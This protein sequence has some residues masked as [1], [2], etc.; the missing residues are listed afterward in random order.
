[1]RYLFAAFAALVYGLVS[2]QEG[3][4]PV[5]GDGRIGVAAE[6]Q[7]LVFV[8]PA[9]AER[10]SPLRSRSPI[11]PGDLV[12]T[13]GRGANAV[14]FD[15]P[16]LGSS[17]LGPGTQVE[18]TR[19]GMR[20]HAGEGECRP[21]EGKSFLLEGPGGA[22]LEV[23]EPGVYAVEGGRLVR[24]KGE[25]RWLRGFRSSTTSEWMGSLLAKV[26]GRVVPLSVGYHKVGVTIRDQI[27]ETVVEESFVNG[28]DA[29]LEGTFFF[30][31]PPDASISGFGMWIGGE[32]VEADVVERQRARR[33]FEDI[34]RRKKD[35]G[36]LEWSGGNLFKAR[37]F[38]IEPHAEKRIRIR[39]TQVLPLEGN[40]VRYRYALRSELLRAHPLRELRM[41]FKISMVRRILDLRSPTHPCRITKTEHAGS[42]EFAAS[43]FTPDRD[44]ELAI[45]VDRDEALELVAHRRGPDGYFALLLAPGD[46]GGGGRAEI[47]DGKPVEVLLVADTSASI[48]ERARREQADFIQALLGMLGPKDRFRLVCADV[49]A[50]WF[51]E[52]SR[53]PTEENLEAA[54]AFL[55]AR[56]SLGWTDFEKCFSEIFEKARPGSLVVYLGDGMPTAGEETRAGVAARLPELAKD[57]DLVCHAVSI[58]N[59]VDPLVLRSLASI[60]GGTVFDAAS[61]PAR[62]AGRLLGEALRPSLKDLEV[63]IRG[64][65]TAMLHPAS[66]PNLPLGRQQILLGRF[67]PSEKPIR[68]EV[69]VRGVL[70]GKRVTYRKAFVLDPADRG[71]SFLPRL[72]ARRHIDALLAEGLGGKIRERVLSLSR[73]YGIITPLTSFLVLESDEERAR[74]GVER[75]VR[76]RDGEEYF[77]EGR[78]H[79]DR[80][81]RR[82]LLATSKRWRVRLRARMLREIRGL[83]TDLVAEGI[84]FGVQ[85]R[86]GNLGFPGA[87]AGGYRGPGDSFAP[88][89]GG[90]RT[91]WKGASESLGIRGRAEGKAS[92][93]ARKVADAGEVEEEFEEEGLE[94]EPGE[95]PFGEEGALTL[96][97]E[98][99]FDDLDLDSEKR[100][101]AKRL[102]RA[103]AYDSGFLAGP[104]SPG[105]LREA[106]HELRMDREAG[107]S[108]RRPDPGIFRE[109]GFPELPPS[110]SPA[111]KPDTRTWTEEVRNLV[112]ILDRRGRLRE[113]PRLFAFEW[114]FERLHPLRAFLLDRDFREGAWSPKAW[115]VT[116]GGLD[117]RLR[118]DSLDGNERRARFPATG[119]A[120]RRARGP[121]DR[122]AFPIPLGD[123]SLGGI[124]RAYGR[125]SGRVLER[126]G[127]RAVIRFAAPAPSA[128]VVLLTLD[129]SRKVLLARE[130]REG[131]RLLER[132][133]W[134]EFVR[135]PGGWIAGLVVTRDGKGRLTARSRLEFRTLSPGDFEA[136]LD[137]ERALW[138]GD[139]VLPARLPS[140]REALSRIREGKAGFADRF[141]LVLDEAA[142]GR[143]GKMFEA[144]EA[145]REAA[146]GKRGLE[147]IEVECLAA[148][149]RGSALQ[150]A[151]LRLAERIA[152]EDPKFRADLADR[153]WKLAS[154]Y[155]GADE[156]GRLLEVLDPASLGLEGARI[157]ALWASRRAAWF[158]AR[159]EWEKVRDLRSEIR[160]LLPLRL[161]PILEYAN[162]LRR[163]GDLRPA[164][165]VLKETLEGA[166]PLSGAERESCHR[167]WSDL[168]WDLRDLVGLEKVLEAWIS[169]GPESPEAWIRL[170]SL[171]VLQ[172]RGEE[173]DRWV[174]ETLA[175]D[176]ASLEEPRK[177]ARVRAAIR[178]A[179]GGGWNLRLRVLDPRAVEALRKLGTA[180]ASLEDGGFGLLREIALN[181]SFRSREA[182]HRLE[183]SIVRMLVDGKVVERASI[184]KLRRL[185]AVV[186]WRSP[187]IEDDSIDRLVA[188]LRARRSTSK[189]PLE[190][191]GLGDLVLSLCDARSDLKTAVRV[192]R[193]LLEDAPAANRVQRI[194]DLMRR[195]SRL[196][197]D[198]A[199]ERE[200]LSLLLDLDREMR[201]EEERISSMPSAVR[202]TAAVLERMRRRR[203]AGRVE[204]LEK[205]PRKERRLRTRKAGLRARRECAAL[206]AKAAEGLSSSTGNWLRV[207]S[208]TF[209][210]RTGEERE[211]V[212]SEALALA[213][214]LPGRKRE[215]G[216]VPGPAER[217]TAVLQERSALVAAYASL[218]RGTPAAL[219]TKVLAF[220]REA[221]KRTREFCDWPYLWFRLL[222]AHDRSG[223]IQETLAAWCEDAVRGGRW[224]RY[225]AWYLVGAGRIEEALRRFAFAEKRLDRLEAEDWELI[226]DCRLLRK[227][228]ALR[229]EAIEKALAASSVGRLDSLLWTE[230]A[231]LNSGAKGGI[232]RPSDRAIRIARVLLRKVSRPGTRIWRIRDLYM[233]TK[234]FRILDGL[235]EGLSG[236]TRGATYEFL[237]RVSQIL[238]QVHEEAV[239]DRLAA[240]LAKALPSASTPLERRAIRLLTARVLAR[241]ARV[242]NRPEAVLE[243]AL[244]ALRLAWQEQ[245]EAGEPVEMAR[246]LASLGRI[247][248]AELA[249]EQRRQLGDLRSLAL[250]GSPD[251]LEISYH[252]YRIEVLYGEIEAAA[253]G[254]ARALD[255]VRDRHEGRLP[256]WGRS[257]LDAAVDWYARLGRFRTAETLLRKEIEAQTR[258][259]TRMDLEAR[260]IRLCLRAL[261]EGG[262]VSLGS[263]RDLYRAL[264]GNLL[265]L[266]EKDPNRLP[267]WL[268]IFC[269]LHRTASKK[270]GIREAGPAL[271][272]F[273][274]GPFFRFRERALD[275]GQT[276]VSTLAGT[277]EG[278][279]GPVAALR[280]LVTSI[281]RE[282][283]WYRRA[284]IEGWSR[285]DWYLAWYRKKAG[286]IPSD[287][288]ERLFAIVAR[289]LERDLVTMSWRS[290][291][292]VRRGWDTFWS[293]RAE[294]FGRIARKVLELKN[295]E[296]HRLFVCRYLWSGLGLRESALAALEAAWR[297]KELSEAGM[298]L[299]LEYLQEAGR[300]KPSLE[301]VEALLE[302]K[303]DHFGFLC[304]KVRALA[305]IGRREAAADLADR[306]RKKGVEE[307][308]WDRSKAAALAKACLEVGLFDR[309]AASYLEAIRDLERRTPG[310]S[311]TKSSWYRKLSE[312]YRKLGR[313]D[314]AVEAAASAIL[315]WG[316]NR[317]GR[318]EALRNLVEVLG[319]VPDL[320]AW[321]ARYEKRVAAEGAD[322]PLIRKT[323]G[324]L[325]LLRGETA[326]A[327]RQLLAARELED[328]DEEVHR[329]LLTACDRLG[330]P[331]EAVE[332]L[333]RWILRFPR[334]TELYGRLAKRLLALGQEDEAERARLSGVEVLP[335]EAESHR[336]LARFFEKGGRFK[337]AAVQWRRTA[338]ARPEDPEGLFGLA[339]VL[340]KLGRSEEARKVLREILDRTYEKRFGE[341][342]RKAAALLRALE[343]D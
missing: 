284:G 147:W 310:P 314:E 82:K 36:L 289:E 136:A 205:L 302:R 112:G 338:S 294:A 85:F 187:R 321:I 130:T 29:R 315:A 10:W 285:L 195:L 12:R 71:N 58:G 217:A 138:K 237:R 39:Y 46:P 250:P 199:A 241:A 279:L 235:V 282:P 84:P 288:S 163:L 30:P 76:M 11:Y 193:G 211:R 308:W 98:E 140:R 148:G 272:R 103:A 78:S 267:L 171:R 42:V 99:S 93:A 115:V 215:E 325:L 277:L 168:L 221:S 54:L 320:D 62:A 248:L 152:K 137:E 2:G 135:G 70:E 31:L 35:P 139:L 13:P 304:R 198:E 219:V 143:W 38:P 212:V 331:R 341:V 141:R 151:V 175:E 343:K 202:W 303:S 172:D 124:E 287:L 179:L 164:A 60:G 153:L 258:R 69:L 149:R 256:T 128:R 116:R 269:S 174:L 190:R 292:L 123:G 295:D 326:K 213:G 104:T 33:I 230:A 342:K 240:R 261:G 87:K 337:E 32:L 144:L 28:T 188:G 157:R 67:R 107:F 91:K 55:E 297:R 59:A 192:A 259:G 166:M 51:D 209:A 222:V 158:A 90:V 50:R 307:K 7:G 73:E 189:D 80:E 89:T 226:A 336:A 231:K 268:Q 134:G 301:V 57:R 19:T 21:L 119:L 18:L 100:V 126:T 191:T 232:S 204:E 333:R 220:H 1:M 214:D 122:K 129:L 61:D 102:R 245:W 169:I 161:E 118:T 177:R 229:E 117:R 16:G 273:A 181:G 224:A 20:F 110:K 286:S 309:A 270:A 79:A 44:F 109:F 340:R 186:D 327:H 6:T 234:D 334:K 216:E 206:F 146:S 111:A 95:P 276:L 154:R 251:W 75:R 156:K 23:R 101:A 236:H 185:A 165:R 322:A 170:L 127:D 72:W 37:V 145:A 133:E 313:F 316:S 194:A 68:G 34:K 180:L 323:L 223:E 263:G 65:R 113:D 45:R 319:A 48:G 182:F 328:G 293:E 41:D 66:P 52:E 330:R 131:T 249:T 196:E 335:E 283:G 94:A 150:A 162:A 49:E 266:M 184:L 253:E 247:P 108:G 3:K 210:V 63:E 227:E 262:V 324:R 27:A 218:L 26:E 271:L 15:R 281:E 255:Q 4:I 178:F 278:M 339:R 329:A 160:R 17:T 88:T 260:R 200:I 290:H 239:L 97:S 228:D 121:V 197:G 244:S 264:R 105:P 311:A 53:P 106:P 92:R 14:L 298:E 86:R 318:T 77:A 9:G 22:R 242:E 64:M 246:Y 252:A 114:T 233:R 132:R 56:P 275:R 207:E 155:L 167:L 40:V 280:F 299:F 74:Y 257:R 305:K 208:L 332:V 265:D 312:A 5:P 47:P 254:L 24:R 8:R 81:L 306:I 83:G 243:E 291:Y 125:W 43:S 317:R 142:R 203:L 173:A 183:A 159:G 300:W 274:E 120:S 96:P 25:P 225:L 296:G 238:D 201:S 176:P